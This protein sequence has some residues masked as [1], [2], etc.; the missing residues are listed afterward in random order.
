M[1]SRFDVNDLQQASLM[2][3][4]ADYCQTTALEVRNTEPEPLLSNSCPRLYFAA[5]GKDS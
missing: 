2:I 1:D 5:G 4:T 3:N